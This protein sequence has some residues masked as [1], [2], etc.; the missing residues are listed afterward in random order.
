VDGFSVEFI[1]AVAAIVIQTMVRR[2]LA[3][4]Q[5][6]DRYNAV[7]TIQWNARIWLTKP[8]VSEKNF[9][10]M[11]HEMYNLAAIQIQSRFRGWWARDCLGVDH[12]CA[13]MIQSVVRCYLQKINYH[14]DIYRIVVCQS[15]I[16]R[17]RAILESR[18][19]LESILTI[20]AW[21]RG[22]TTRQWLNDVL[23]G[24]RHERFVESAAAIVIQCTWRSY[25][26]QMNYIHS[27]ADILLVQSIIRRFIANRRM[28]PLLQS[29]RLKG[30][31]CQLVN[32]YS[33]KREVREMQVAQKEIDDGTKSSNN[34][35]S[36]V[37]KAWKDRE[38]KN[39]NVM[40]KDQE[41]HEV[42]QS[43]THPRRLRLSQTHVLNTP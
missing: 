5:A 3:I 23:S 29:S 11:E 17:N 7:R 27:L 4:F 20:Q 26:A 2:R 35:M 16:R 14:Y 30:I 37:L 40:R 12:Y 9:F 22:Y 39:N 34:N 10:S 1:E 19:R 43:P 42:P 8:R 36:D 24:G 28:A 13:S 15:V 38:T 41:G 25:D 6:Y 33:P 18:L 31:Q 32:K 21:F